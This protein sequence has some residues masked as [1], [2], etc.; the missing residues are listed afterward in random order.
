MA[1]LLKRSKICK[2]CGKKFLPYNTIQPVCSVSCLME[3]NSKKQVTKR[4][5]EFKKALVTHQSSINLLQTLFNTWVRLRDEGKPCISCG[6]KL[7]DKYDAGHYF[8]CGAYPN[9]RFNPDNVHAQCVRCNQHK[10]GNIA[11]YAKGLTLRIG[12]ERFDALYE[13]RKLS[14]KLSIPEIAE[15][16]MAYKQKISGYKK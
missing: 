10:H 1:K 12:Q 2:M 9:L 3:Y 7:G 5:K 16:I 13:Q 6:S 8:S 4:V 11:E 15:L 14:T